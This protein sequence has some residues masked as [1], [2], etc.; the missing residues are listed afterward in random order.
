MEVEIKLS[1]KDWESYHSFLG[2]EAPRKYYSGWWLTLLNAL[3]WFLGFIIVMATINSVSSFHWPTAITVS[4]LFLLLMLNHFLNRPRV[5]MASFA[6]EKDGSFCGVHFFNLTSESLIA[7][8]EG[9]FSEHSW[10]LFKRVERSHGLI[11]LFIDKANAF[12]FPESE[13]S[14]PE[15]FYSFTKEK[16]NEYNKVI[17]KDIKS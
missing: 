7:K 1:V 13:L 5:L 16:V 6:P 2:S 15:E 17:K 9:Y 10:S 12:V 4:I 3:V 14:N 8:S 11:M